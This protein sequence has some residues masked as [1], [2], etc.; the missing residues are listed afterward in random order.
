MIAGVEVSTDG[1][2]SWHPATGDENWTY[3]WSPQVSGPVTIQSRAVD[4]SINLETPTTG[5]TVAVGAFPYLTVFPGSATPAVVNT[6]DA[7]AVELGLQFSSSVAGT[8]TG[9]RFYKSSQDTG[10]HTGELWSSTGTLLATVTF[11]NETASGWQ[12][13]SFSNPV[14]ITPGQTYTVSYHTNA[15]HYSNTEEFFASPVKSGPLTAAAGVFAYST[16]SHFPTSSFDSTNFWVDVMFN[17]ATGVTNHAPTAVADN[18]LTEIQNSAVV[19]DASQL[20]AND[21]DLDGDTLSIAS[22]NAASHGTVT[23]TTQSNPQNSTILSRRMPAT[24]ARRRFPTRSR[25]GAAE[26]PPLK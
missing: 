17:P 4:D 26:P 22:V 2:T 16:T 6:T 24:P 21:S 20:L 18:G 9:V 25:T 5:Q 1:G 7:S 13:A 15:G 12:S 3:T 19:I 8:A 14:T 10:V 11:S 23:L